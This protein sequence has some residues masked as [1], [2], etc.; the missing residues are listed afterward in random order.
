MNFKTGDKVKLFNTDGDCYGLP[1]DLIKRMA[2]LPYT[3]IL[4]IDNE[5]TP[6]IWF[7]EIPGYWNPKWF[8]K[9][10]TQLEFDFNE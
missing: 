5:F 1:F 3:T 6:K 9:V 10:N 8:K 4:R 2:A 7:Y